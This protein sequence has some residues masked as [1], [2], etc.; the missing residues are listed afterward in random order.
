MKQLI[1][2]NSFSLHNC[3]CFSCA[4]DDCAL[5]LRTAGSEVDISPCSVPQC[6]GTMRVKKNQRGYILA[7]TSPACKSIWW[8]PKFVRTGKIA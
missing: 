2:P 3:R 1:F 4:K 5:A 8:V 7:C 6:T